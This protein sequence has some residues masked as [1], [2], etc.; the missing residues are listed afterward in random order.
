MEGEGKYKGVNQRIL[1][2][3]FETHYG[4][5]LYFLLG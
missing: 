4:R 5:I 2:R 1:E 3:F